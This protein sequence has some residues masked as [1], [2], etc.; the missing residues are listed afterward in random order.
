MPH[1]YLRWRRK[2]VIFVYEFWH[3]LHANLPS[4]L[5]KQFSSTPKKTKMKNY[6]K[7]SDENFPED[8]TSKT[9]KPVKSF[10]IIN[11]YSNSVLL[12]C[13]S[14]NCTQC[15]LCT[16]TRRIDSEKWV[17]SCSTASNDSTKCCTW[18][19]FCRTDDKRTYLKQRGVVYLKTPTKRAGF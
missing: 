19:T 15:A 17:P 12:R 8:G 13:A 7:V 6:F 16:Y 5:H 9:Q 14:S 3:F 4:G 11:Y 1:S 2:L 10:F 18:R